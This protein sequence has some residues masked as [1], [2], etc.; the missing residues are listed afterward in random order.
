M[1]NN[2]SINLPAGYNIKIYNA[3]SDLTDIE[4]Q[5]KELQ[6][7]P[8]EDFD[9]IL[10]ILESRAEVIGP[11]IVVIYYHDYPRAILIGI[12]E[13][14]YLTYKIS[15]KIFSGPQLH[16]LTVYSVATKNEDCSLYSD[17]FISVLIKCLKR[18]KV[19][20]VKFEFINTNSPLFKLAQTR[21]KFVSRDLFPDFAI[22]NI[23]LL[24]SSIQKL[25]RDIQSSQRHEFFR[26]YRSAYKKYSGKVH[27]KCYKNL[28]E[29]DTICK[30]AKT[31][32]ASSL[33]GA[34]G[35]G[36]KTDM[37]TKN[38]LILSARQGWLRAYFLFL[39]NEP[40][41]FCVGINYKNTLYF[42]HSGFNQNYRSARPGIVLIK[43]IL[44]DIYEND[45]QIKKN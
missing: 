3:I 43:Y 39:N 13:K 33:Q 24:P 14:R 45:T 8:T 34:A 11:Y 30:N 7:Y 17:V 32:S 37:E 27:F 1:T 15:Y 29:V 19:D 25:Y 28:T 9:I 6:N 35:F 44:E 23:L 22:N 16:L 5:W 2:Q 20:L 40:C 18:K 41:A 31:I 21:P 36:F 26:K 10:N 12:F 38:F 4:V 42:S